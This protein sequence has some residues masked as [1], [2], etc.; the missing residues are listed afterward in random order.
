[1]KPDH[2]RDEHLRRIELAVAKHEQLADLGERI[3]ASI[4]QTG[5]M[6]DASQQL[7]AALARLS[8]EYHALVAD[9]E[10]TGRVLE[11]REKIRGDCLSCRDS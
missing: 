4:E 2:L 9:V 11:V 3:A 7:I 1:M 5:A 8:D 6:S 10:S